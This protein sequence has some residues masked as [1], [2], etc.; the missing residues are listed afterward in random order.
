[1][2]WRTYGWTDFCD[3]RVTFSTEKWVVY[4]KDEFN[5]IQK[6]RTHQ[7]I[8]RN[9]VFKRRSRK[10]K[11]N[12]KFEGRKGKKRNK[13]HPDRKGKKRNKNLPKRKSKKRNK[14]HKNRKISKQSTVFKGENCDFIDFGSVGSLGSGCVDGTKMV[15]KNK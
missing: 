11:R 3:Y 6:I 15:L 4:C 13:N 14:N 9:T 2:D 10:N 8:K 12:K 7:Q 5:K 1:M